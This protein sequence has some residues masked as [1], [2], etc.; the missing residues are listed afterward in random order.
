MKEDTIKQDPQTE[1]EHNPLYDAARKVL[2]ASIGAMALAQEEIEDFINKLV[3]RGEIAE[4]DGKRLFHELTE[5]RKKST[6]R[7][8]D[9]VAS[10]VE[11][12][13]DRMSIASKSDLDALSKKIASL[14]KM[15]DN[16]NKPQA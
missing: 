10:R 11:E 3:E 8:E 12:I 7:A 14:T 5:K 16:L 2:L 9:E 6:Q 1:E 4:K 13:L 15:I